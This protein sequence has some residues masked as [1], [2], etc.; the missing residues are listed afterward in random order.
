MTFTAGS[1][2]KRSV[3]CSMA[4]GLFFSMPMMYSSEPRNLFSSL[5]PSSIRSPCSSIT[6]WSLVMKGSHSAPLIRTVEIWLFCAAASLAHTGKAAP[7]SPT[8][9]L[10]RT[11]WRNSSRFVGSGI[12][13][14][15]HFSI[16]PSL[17]MRIA[18]VLRPPAL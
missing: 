15:G 18:V 7:P 16:L 4:S 10:S 9:P 1:S 14:S 12:D 3:S 13:R 5:M 6:R 11:H 2:R 8:T 17:S